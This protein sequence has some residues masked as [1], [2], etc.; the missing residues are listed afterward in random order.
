[1]PEKQVHINNKPYMLNYGA[2]QDEQLDQ[3]VDF[4]NRRIQPYA[5]RFSQYSESYLL[6]LTLLDMA[7]ELNSDPSSALNEELDQR[8]KVLAHHAEALVKQA[9]EQ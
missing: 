4:I 5:E 3:L 2:G 9:E 1:M 6:L 8:L 7:N